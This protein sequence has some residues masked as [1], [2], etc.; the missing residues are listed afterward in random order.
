M[1]QGEEI[2]YLKERKKNKSHRFFFV[3]LVSIAILTI[4]A[5]LIYFFFFFGKGK[6]FR[7][8]ALDESLNQSSASEEAENFPLF[9]LESAKPFYQVGEKFKVTISLDLGEKTTQGADIFLRY[10]P[11]QLLLSELTG[12]F[13]SEAEKYLQIN[14]SAFT[15]FPYFNLD[16][17]KGLIVFSSLAQPNEKIGGAIIVAAI[18]FKALQIGETELNFDFI[19]GATDDTNVAFEGEDILSAVENLKIN[20]K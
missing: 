8:I 18:E 6:D 1:S 7:E 15:V 10:N 3:F 17:T 4:L 12:H 5:V 14:D 9:F 11:Q 13:S 16:E 20:I 2:L 19:L